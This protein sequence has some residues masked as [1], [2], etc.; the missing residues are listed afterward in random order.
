MSALG[1]V[2]HVAPAITDDSREFWTSGQ[3]GELRIFRCADCQHWVHPPVPVCRKCRSTRV[4]AQAVSGKGTL[5]SFTVNH[6]PWTDTFNGPYVLGLVEL[7]EEPGVHVLTNI[8]DCAREEIRVGMALEV[9]F[10]PEGEA[11]LPLFRP[12]R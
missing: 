8:V 7:D 6:H 10:K 5:Y 11:W 9:T 1:V 4:A 2:P 3:T 12:R